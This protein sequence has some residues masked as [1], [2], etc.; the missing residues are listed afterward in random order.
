SLQKFS[1][2][3]FDV[4]REKKE[5]TFT[6]LTKDGEL[7]LSKSIA[8]RG[9]EFEEVIGKLICVRKALGEDIRYIDKYVESNGDYYLGTTGAIMNLENGKFVL[10]DASIDFQKEIN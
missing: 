9:D 5:V 4:N 3:K 2:V 1:Q 6:G 10:R 8:R 7:K